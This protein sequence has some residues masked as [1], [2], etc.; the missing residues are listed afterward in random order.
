[1]VISSYGAQSLRVQVLQ[2]IGHE[3]S[4]Q[5][6]AC[7]TAGYGLIQKSLRSPVAL[8]R[9]QHLTQQRDDRSN[10]LEIS[11]ELLYIET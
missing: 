8:Q 10:S 4:G 6:H 5:Y 1:M 9:L 2:S 3:V 7:F 11:V